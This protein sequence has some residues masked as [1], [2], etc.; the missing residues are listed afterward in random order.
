VTKRGAR[1]ETV[2]K[3][4]KLTGRIVPFPPTAGSVRSDD[5]RMRYLEKSSFDEVVIEG[6]KNVSNR[7][8]SKKSL[9]VKAKVYNTRTAPKR[10]RLPESN[11]L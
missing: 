1:D 5:G 3:K 9:E 4:S 7:R 2:F 11:M 10:K 8:G 6:E